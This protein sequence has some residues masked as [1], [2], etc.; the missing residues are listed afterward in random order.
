MNFRQNADLNSPM[1]ARWERF[2]DI[3]L[4]VALGLVLAAVLASSLSA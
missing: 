4:A 2:A 3:A 1:P